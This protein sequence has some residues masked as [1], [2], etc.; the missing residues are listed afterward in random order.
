M[1]NFK[2]RLLLLSSLRGG[3]SFSPEVKDFIARVIADGGKVE[4]PKCIGTLDA[5]FVM[6]PVAYKPTVLYS[7]KREVLD[8]IDR[9]TH[10]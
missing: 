5:D 4:S 8:V 1:L 2:K 7:Q 3:D 10:V 9:K 6:Y